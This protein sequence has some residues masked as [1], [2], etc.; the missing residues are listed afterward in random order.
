M[1]AERAAKQL[2]EDP[3][4]KLDDIISTLDLCRKETEA[5][6]NLPPPIKK[7]EPKQE[8]ETMAGNEEEHIIAEPKK[9]EGPDAPPAGD[10][11]RED[12]PKVDAEMTN[13]EKK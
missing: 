8:D 6:F 2:H 3:S 12:A 5:I 13:E 11:P 9:E 7:E 10:A 1:K 4:F